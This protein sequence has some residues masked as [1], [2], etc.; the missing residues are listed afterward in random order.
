M[1]LSTVSGGFN[2]GMGGTAW[3]MP[4]NMEPPNFSAMGDELG[5]G[6]LDGMDFNFSPDMS[7]GG[8]AG[9]GD[10]HQRVSFSAQG[11]PRAGSGANG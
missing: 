10:R 11:G 7:G 5:G 6:A 4:F 8:E 3:F 2:G 9:T 1:V